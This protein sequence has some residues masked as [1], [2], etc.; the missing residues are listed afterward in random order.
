MLRTK[1]SILALVVPLGG[2]MSP[3][4]VGSHPVLSRIQIRFEEVVED[5]HAR[6]DEDWYSDWYGNFLVNASG[7]DARG[8]CWHWQEAV[9]DGMHGYVKSL[10]W[11]ATGVVLNGGTS[12]E[13]HAVIV[14][15]PRVI[16]AEEILERDPPR[17]VWVLDAWRRGRPEIYIFDTWVKEG[18]IFASSAALEDLEKMRGSARGSASRPAAP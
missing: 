11:Q 9:F 12:L 6:T 16:S 10:G 4:D 5:I 15:D 14:F 2:C 1:L 17:P 18:A 7:E 3:V 13:H 8:L